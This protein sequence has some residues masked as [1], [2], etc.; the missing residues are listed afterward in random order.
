MKIVSFYRDYMGYTG[1]HQKVF[2]YL[3]HCSAHPH[4]DSELYIQSR[5][6]LQSPFDVIKQRWQQQ[7][8]PDKADVIFL[9]GLD[10]RAYQPFF[11]EHQP[12]IN[13]IQHLRHADPS[14]AHFAFL[15]HKAIRICVSKAV[16]EAIKPFANG[17]V[18]TIKMGHEI[19]ELLVSDKDIDLYILANKKPGWGEHLAKYANSLGFRVKLTK[20]TVPKENVFADMARA[21]ISLVLPNKTEGFYLPGIEAM[22]LSNVAIV[23]NCVANLEYM[24]KGSNA[25]LCANTLDGC[26]KAIHLGWN[27]SKSEDI[28]IR[29]E[30]GKRI[31]CSYNLNNEALRFHNVLNE[32]DNLWRS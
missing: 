21:N 12:K 19:P 29:A 7:Y 27:M 20:Q 5:D 28:K 30:K 14:Q 15:K 9:A 10:W 26:K 17:P 32:L 1:G 3:Q 18:I 11:N 24:K 31:S 6:E 4:F 22:S 25:I 13:L 8:Q 16:E 23:P 2:D